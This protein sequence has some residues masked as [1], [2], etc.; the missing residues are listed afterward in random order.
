MFVCCSS[1]RGNGDDEQAVVGGDDERAREQT[2]KT[3]TPNEQ[4]GDD[5]GRESGMGQQGQG[6]REAG[7]LEWGDGAGLGERQVERGAGKCE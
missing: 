6:E 2:P 1:E 4:R 7:W 3:R 5:C